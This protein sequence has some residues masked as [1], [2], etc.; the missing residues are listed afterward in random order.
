M[1]F[2]MQR[3]QLGGFRNWEW[4]DSWGLESSKGILLCGWPLMPAVTWDHDRNPGCHLG[5]LHMASP[6]DLGF[7]TAWQPQGGWAPYVAAQG[8]K[9]S[10][11]ASD[12]ESACRRSH[13][14]ALLPLSTGYKQLTNPA[15]LPPS[16]VHRKWSLIPCLNGGVTWTEMSMGQER[17]RCPSLEF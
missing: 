8:S 3:P 7:L 15:P 1:Y 13:A 16:L 10:I 17:R 6:C 4:L 12:V 14:A 5:Y 9:E 2:L 11:P